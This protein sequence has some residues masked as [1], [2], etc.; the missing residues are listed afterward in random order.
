MKLSLSFLVS[1]LL[2]SSHFIFAEGGTKEA[3]EKGQ[4]DAM[5]AKKDAE[6]DINN[7]FLRG[8]GKINAISDLD[9]EEGDY[10]VVFKKNKIK[11]EKTE[12]ETLTRKT[13]GE[14]KKTYSKVLQGFSAR[15]TRQAVNE[16]QSNLNVDYIEM[17]FQVSIND[18]T[19][20]TQSSDLSWG[21]DRIEGYGPVG[22]YSY[23]ADGPDQEVHVYVIDSGINSA[24]DDFVGRLGVGFGAINNTSG[25]S[26]TWEDCNG[27]G[28]HVAGTIGGTK[29]GVA[30]NANIVLHAVR[31]LDCTGSGS[32]AD[33][34]EAYDWVAKQCTDKICVANGSFGSAL[35]QSSNTGA[36]GLVEA[37]VVFAVAAGNA[38]I[39]ACERSPASAQGVIT[40]G[41][42]DQNDG[43]SSFS[44]YGECVEIF[45][46]VRNIM[47]IFCTVIF[48]SYFSLPNIAYLLTGK[49]YHECLDG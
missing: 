2:L 3:N 28:T 16:L 45:A 32:M 15:L 17:D 25:I 35:S 10:I 21:L 49:S 18:C 23:F 37:G 33:I 29:Y 6:K 30:K 48:R 19:T 42:T 7:I 46:P 31:V 4:K 11:N 12:A 20:A 41:S 24:H 13:K 47:G 27:H 38:N 14:L 36:A 44:C 43:R 5:K 8:N 1:F 22:S 40:V 9:D 39:D 26:G 34:L